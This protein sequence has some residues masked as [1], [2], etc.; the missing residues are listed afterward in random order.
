MHVLCQYYLSSPWIGRDSCSLK[1]SHWHSLIAIALPGTWD[2]QVQARPNCHGS[3]VHMFFILIV[4]GWWLLGANA[5]SVTL[6]SFKATR[7]S[8]RGAEQEYR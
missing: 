2:A 3:V 5:L 7:P 4:T 1:I 6:A 8:C